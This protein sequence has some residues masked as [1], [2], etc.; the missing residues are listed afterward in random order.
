MLS[1]QINA[2]HKETISTHAEQLTLL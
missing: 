2:N 1:M